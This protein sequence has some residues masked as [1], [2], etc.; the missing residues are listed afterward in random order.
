M[1]STKLP[2]SA[3]ISLDAQQAFDQVEWRYMFAALDKFG[4]GPKFMNILKMLY[5]SPQSSVLTNHERSPP[6]QLHRGTRQGCCLSPMLFALALEPLA[7]AI[8]ANP[9]V[10]G[11]RCGTTEC[12]IG[13]YADDVILTLSDLKV[14]LSPLLSLIRD[15]G[16]LSGFTINWGKSVL[17]PLS[18]GLDSTFLSNLPLR[19]PLIWGLTS[20]GIQNFFLSLIILI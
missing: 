6:F 11:I 7:I 16:R 4:F 12:T 8:R 19:V 10:C 2:H 17:M 13:L 18:N 1:Y 3:V 15:F 9:Q 14:S 20:P 5:A